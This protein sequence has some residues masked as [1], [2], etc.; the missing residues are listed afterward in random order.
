[1]G[2]LDAFKSNPMDD[3]TVTLPA[4]RYEELIKTETELELVRSFA[5]NTKGYL[6]KE[7]LLTLL[8]VERNENDE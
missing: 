2:L 5:A 4:T 7:D 6:A 3:V 1:M 8:K